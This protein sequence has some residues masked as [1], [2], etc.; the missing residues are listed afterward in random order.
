MSNDTT[1]VAG[2]LVKVKNV[3]K[4]RFSNQKE[5]YTAIWIEDSGIKKCLMFT[6]RELK[7]AERRAKRNDKLWIQESTTSY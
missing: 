4:P 3:N 7:I 6:D 1:G 2:Q 5:V